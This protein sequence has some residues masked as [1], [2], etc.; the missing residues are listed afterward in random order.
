MGWNVKKGDS[1]LH[2]H[3]RLT[4]QSRA[5]APAPGGNKNS[6]ST[7][8]HPE[9]NHKSEF[10][11]KMACF[12]RRPSVE[13]HIFPPEQVGGPV[14]H[15]ILKLRHKLTDRLKNLARSPCFLQKPEFFRANGETSISVQVGEKANGRHRRFSAF[16]EQ[17]V[18]LYEINRMQSCIFCKGLH[19]AILFFHVMINKISSFAQDAGRSENAG[20]PDTNLQHRQECKE[21]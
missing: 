4:S 18:K 10:Y 14:G 1:V 19:C 21:N 20:Y 11:P 12:S 8:A 17:I 15:P 6:V 2:G 16:S 3:R 5:F 13:N 9:K 7:I